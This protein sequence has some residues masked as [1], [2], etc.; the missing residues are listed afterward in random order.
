MNQRQISRVENR[1]LQNLPI[2]LRDAGE[3]EAE[4]R[5]LYGKAIVFNSLSQDLGGFREIIAPS[6]VTKT[7]SEADVLALAYHDSTS[8][9]GRTSSGTL[10]LNASDESLNFE[11][12]L[13][14]TS[15]ADDLAVLVARGDVVGSS[16]GFYTIADSW[17]EDENGNVIRTVTE[18]ALHHVAPTP[19]PAYLDTTAAMRS[20]AARRDLD[21]DTVSDAAKRGGLKNLLAGVGSSGGHGDAEDE[22]RVSTFV[23]LAASYVF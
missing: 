18:L 5:I 9:L 4:N 6:A 20:L 11:I 21:F 15:V 1:T 19:D 3:T 13:P 12:D 14:D 7:I 8:L 16:F 17:D 2:A 23:P 10:R 22:S